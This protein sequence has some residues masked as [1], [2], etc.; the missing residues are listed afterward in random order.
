MPT[1]Q[2]TYPYV[3]Q[4]ALP[5]QIAHGDHFTNTFICETAAGIGFGVAV[6]Q[7]TADKQAVLGGASAAVFVGVTVQDKTIPNAAI[8]GY[9]Q[10]DNMGVMSR[11]HIWV[12]VPSAVNKGDDAT[13]A[14]TTGIISSAATSGTQFAIAG[15]RFMTSAGINGFAK[16]ALG[17]ALPSA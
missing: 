17:G 15:A 11:G 6:S 2:S 9:R 10:Y 1:V 16:L 13:F 12:Q 14:S 4:I 5:G 7:G 3:Q 8:D